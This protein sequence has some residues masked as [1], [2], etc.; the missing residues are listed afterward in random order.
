MKCRTHPN[1]YGKAQGEN[2][3]Q[4]R[5]S[6]ACAGAQVLQVMD[7]GLGLEEF[8]GVAM[9]IMKCGAQI[10][11][12][13]PWREREARARIVGILCFGKDCISILRLIEAACGVRVPMRMG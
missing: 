1:Q 4:L 11:S 7:R 2:T 5:V 3:Q 6:S 8:H 10:L 13:M 9:W 12:M